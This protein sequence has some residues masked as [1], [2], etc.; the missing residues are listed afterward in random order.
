MKT[1]FKGGLFGQALWLSGILLALGIMTTERA[2]AKPLAYNTCSANRGIFY[3]VHVKD[4]GWLNPACNMGVAGT[5]HQSRRVEAIRIWSSPDAEV[6]YKVHVTGVGWW[7]GCN[8]EVAGTVGQG[9]QVDAIAVWSPTVTICYEIHVAEEGWMD[10]PPTEDGYYAP[11]FCSG[12][13]ARAQ[14]KEGRRIEA[15]RIWRPDMTRKNRCPP[16]YRGINC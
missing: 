14:K 16:G 2:D 5:T 3:Q 4:F 10:N 6:C 13:E 8:G 9:K 15:I 7:T 12:Q 11:T 1:S